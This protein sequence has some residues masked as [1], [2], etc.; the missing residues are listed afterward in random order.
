MLKLYGVGRGRPKQVSS[1]TSQNNAEAS[2]SASPSSSAAP[3]SGDTGSSSGV[4][5][6]SSASADPQERRRFPGEIRLQKELED[7]DLPHQ[8]VLT[9]SSL[10]KRGA[11]EASSPQLLG[12]S[13]LNMQLKISPDDGFWRGGKFLFFIAIPANYPHDPPKVKCMDKIYHPNID[14]HG[15]VCL[16]ILREDWKPVLSI[17]SVMYGLL[18]LFLEP[19]PSD[20][21]NQEAAALLRSNPSEF[22]RQ[23]RRTLHL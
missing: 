10:E 15:N 13:L 18:H 2:S 20:P 3:L 6:A 14:Q 17:S 5:G 1:S 19:N 12:N 21:L 7:L 9:F 4:S 16:N 23:V 11:A 8:C 22:Q